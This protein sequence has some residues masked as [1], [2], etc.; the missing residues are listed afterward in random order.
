MVGELWD[1]QGLLYGPL[2]SGS[3][4]RMSLIDVAVAS[5]LPGKPVSTCTAVASATGS[6]VRESI[7]VPGTLV[8]VGIGGTVTGTFV[9][10]G[11]T[12]VD[13]GTVARDGVGGARFETAVGVGTIV[14]VVL[15]PGVVVAGS[16]AMAKVGN[17]RTV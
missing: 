13:A 4:D 7:P 16:T 10:L 11:T 17:A 9:T 6:C 14:T 1:Q 15:I 3:D 12:S 8:S 5:T 2:E